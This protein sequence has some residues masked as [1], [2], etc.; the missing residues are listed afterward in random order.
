M[1]EQKRKCGARKI[2]GLYFVSNPQDFLSCISLPHNVTTCPCCYEGIKFS[3]G[4]KWFIPNK[5]FNNIE[6][7]CSGFIESACPIKNNCPLKSKEKSGIMW[8]GNQFYTPQNF[9]EEAKEQGISKRISAVPNEFELGKTWVFLAHNSGGRNDSN[10]KVPAI[11]HVFK[12][13]RIEKIVSKT[14]YKNKDEMEKLRSK[15]I[16]PIV[17]DDNDF[18]HRGSAYDKICGKSLFE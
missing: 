14:Q 6:E 18:D 4:Y 12:P 15:G 2:G 1:I 11:F 3:R 10:K 13:T 5:L 16:I 17:V 8:V 7:T 9:I